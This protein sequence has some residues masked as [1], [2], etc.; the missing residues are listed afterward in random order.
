[1][2]E[3]SRMN[4]FGRI[5]ICSVEESLLVEHIMVFACVLLHSQVDE[6]FCVTPTSFPIL[7]STTR[8]KQINNQRTKRT[9]STRNKFNQSTV[10]DSLST[11][12]TRMCTTG[13]FDVPGWHGSL[14]VNDSRGGIKQFFFFFSSKKNDASRKFVVTGLLEINHI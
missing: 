6:A 3:R 9:L 11:A 10:R 13:K 7:H 8:R 2:T 12:V 14:C 5:K 4:H 1:M